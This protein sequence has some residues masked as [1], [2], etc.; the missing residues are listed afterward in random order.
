MATR[1]FYLLLS[2]VLTFS[3]TTGCLG[4]SP[5]EKETRSR[6]E[7]KAETAKG[8]IQERARSGE[9][10]GGVLAT[11]EAAGSR[12]QKGDVVGG[13]TL[14]DQALATLQSGNSLRPLYEF[15]ELTT[16]VYSD[17]QPV[18]IL[19][20]DASK[21]IMEPFI[22]RDGQYLLFN[23]GNAAHSTEGKRNLDL[24]HAKRIDDYTFQYLGEIR[25]A[26]SDMVDGAPSLDQNNRLFFT[27]P[28]DYQK[29]LAT[30]YTG[31]FK[32]GAATN[33][34]LLRG[35]I[36]PNKPGWLNMDVEISAD[37]KTLVY[38][39][40]QWNTEINI[41]KTSNLHVAQWVGDR[42]ERQDDSDAIFRNINTEELEY[43]PSV[44]ADQRM[45]SFTRGRLTFKDG[46]FRGMT[47]RILVATRQ[48]ANEPFG[49]PRRIRAVTGFV[50][51][52]TITPDKKILYYHKQEADTFRLYGVR[53]TK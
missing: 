48:S 40:N 22:T 44:S 41:P 32:N 36:S 15:N 53:R 9:D 13:E 34:G 33:L 31:V 4:G 47:S 50:E 20:F 10:I 26:N 45:L 11:M 12:F 42:F 5:T 19:G 49:K 1:Y 39:V 43:A 37:G 25:G 16:D 35:N 23:N 2:L 17:P 18:T 21:G 52:S 38:S 29:K 8:L 6:I 30:I 3:M 27:S 51:G 28:R 7:Q 46:E 24:H 14:L